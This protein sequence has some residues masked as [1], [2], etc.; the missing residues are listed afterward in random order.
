MHMQGPA[1]H[2]LNPATD[3]NA[4]LCSIPDEPACRVLPAFC[5]TTDLTT[6]LK[7]VHLPADWGKHQPLLL[8]LPFPPSRCTKTA[9][10]HRI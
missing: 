10:A 6:G 9:P 4:H 1:W 8:L 3:E 5:R 2:W 7:P